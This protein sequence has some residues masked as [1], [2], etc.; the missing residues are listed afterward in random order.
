MGV[1]PRMGAPANYNKGQ[2][3]IIVAQSIYAQAE[4]PLHDI[5]D[6]LQLGNRTF[7]YARAGATGLSAGFLSEAAILA[8]GVSYNQTKCPV[9]VAA[10]AGT[11]KV[12]L[13]AISGTQTANIFANGFAILDDT[14]PT[15]DDFY[16]MR[17]KSNTS[18]LTSGVASYIELYDELPIALTTSDYVD[19]TANP[20]NAVVIANYSTPTSPVVGVPIIPVTAYYY[21]WIQTYGPCGVF[22]NEGPLTNGKLVVRSTATDGSVETYSV[23]NSV[24]PATMTDPVGY[25]MNIGTDAFCAT[26]FLKIAA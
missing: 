24:T 12:Y 7:F 5:G 19:L 13:T 9:V 10:A 2:G 15:P 26:V 4:N 14:S 1:N 18:L 25:V 11:K 23:A 20:Y 16:T 8:G 3:Q 6:R 21:F 17:I 22:S